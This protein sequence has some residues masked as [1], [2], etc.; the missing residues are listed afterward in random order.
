VPALGRACDTNDWAMN[1][2]G[3]VVAVLVAS[4]LIALVGRAL[5]TPV[6]NSVDDSNVRSPRELSTV[7]DKVGD[8]SN[9]RS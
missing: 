7:V 2:V 9:G 5:S 6:D 3:T 8:E 4:A 1:S